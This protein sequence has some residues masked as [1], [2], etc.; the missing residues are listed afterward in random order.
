MITSA[1]LQFLVFLTELLI[2][3]NIDTQDT[4]PWSVVFVPMYILSIVSI[5]T[6]IWNCYRKRSIE[7]CMY[8]CIFMYSYLYLHVCNM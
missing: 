2:A 7:V 1:G 4:I 8:V 5:P 3:I 6:C